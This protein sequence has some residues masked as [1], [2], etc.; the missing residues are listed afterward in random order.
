M[1]KLHDISTLKQEIIA[2]DSSESPACILLCDD[3]VANIQV[4][5]ASLKSTYAIKVAMNG[6][7]CIELALQ[8]P[9][10]DLI[11]LDVDMPDMNGYEVCKIL[12]ANELSK[13]IPIIFLTGMDNEADEEYGLMLGAQDYI[14]KPIRPAIVK[15]RVKTHITIKKQRDAL[16]QMALHDQLT[17]LYNRNYL[18]EV[19]QQK[20]T[21]AFRHATPLTVFMLDID[22]FKKINDT[23]GHRKGDEVLTAVAK[24]LQQKSRAYD[25]VARFGGEE[26][27]MVLSG[28]PANKTVSKAQS[29]LMEIETLMPSGIRV[30][31][32]LGIAVLSDQYTQLE[33]LIHQ[34]DMALYK[35]KA[36]GRNCVVLSDE[37]ISD[38]E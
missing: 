35:A 29:I 5:A 4:S 9:Q 33:E 19:G 16:T 37:H 36:N 1:A 6:Q 22:H 24:L 7:R 27:V 30:T 3:E 2:D 14:T 31:S 26:F 10:P 18:L 13:N 12:K 34:A 25:V 32:S 20:L 23:Y 11:L 8:T 38:L 21:Y 17:G 28:C 15:A